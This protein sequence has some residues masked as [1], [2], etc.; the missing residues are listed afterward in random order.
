MIRLKTQEEIAIMKEGGAIHSAILR[1]LAYAVRVGVSAGE[2]DTLA[3]ALFEE[4]KVQ[5][6]FLG[7]TPEGVSYPYPSAVCV[8]VNDE[9]VHGI[10]L[11]DVVFQEGDVVSLDIGVVYKNLITDAAI[12]LVVGDGSEEDKKLVNITKEALMVG[13]KAAK[14][15]NTVGDIGF[16]IEQFVKPYGYGIVK[17]LAGHGVGYEVHEDPYIP[18]YGKSG[19]GEKLVPGMV[20]AIE[21]MLT[22]GG[23]EVA[24]TEDEYTYVTYDGSNAAHF[25]HTVAITEQGPLILTK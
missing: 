18:N 10:P 2:I 9:V 4:Y 3:R 17:I 7:Y 22:R 19:V 12:T 23:E 11:E 8:S 14:P 20:I 25:E 15:G 16:A 13:I 24:A 1:D 5:P 6:A 21:P